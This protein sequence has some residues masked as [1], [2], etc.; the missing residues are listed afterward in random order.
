MLDP[1]DVLVPPYERLFVEFQHQPNRRDID[2][3]AWG[4]LLEANRVDG[5]RLVGGGP[6]PPTDITVDGW[7]TAPGVVGPLGGVVDLLAGAAGHEA[8]HALKL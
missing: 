3:N 7:I 2:L 6:S 8:L 5:Q 1:L 4:V